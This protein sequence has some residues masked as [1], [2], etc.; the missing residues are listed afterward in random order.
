MADGELKITEADYAAIG[1]VVIACT[2]LKNFLAAM[3]ANIGGSGES[4]RLGQVDF[5]RN[6]GMM[7]RARRRPWQDDR[8]GTT[9]WH[10]RRKWL[11]PR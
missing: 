6:S 2:G 9:A 4:E 3:S 8:A 5:P 11:L 1:M 10:S 7:L